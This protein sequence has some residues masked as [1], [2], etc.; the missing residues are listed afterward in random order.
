M[1]NS[2]IWKSGGNSG[3]CDKGNLSKS[4]TIPGVVQSQATVSLE[5]DIPLTPLSI[6]TS[7]LPLTNPAWGLMDNPWWS[8]L[9]NTPEPKEVRRIVSE[10]IP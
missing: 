10:T 3:D 7:Y 6:K 9:S 1:G 4:D 2:I 5:M 8:H